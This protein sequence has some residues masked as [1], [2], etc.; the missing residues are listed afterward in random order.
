MGVRVRVVVPPGA[1]LVAA[2]DPFSQLGKP[3][4]ARLLMPTALELSDTAQVIRAGV[5]DACVSVKAKLVA[6][7]A[8]MLMP[9][10]DRKFAVMFST[11]LMVTEVEA[12]PALATVPDQPLKV[13]LAPAV[14]LTGTTVPV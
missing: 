5:A 1:T 8:E 2:R 11:A 4:I 10:A 13:N 3:D 14:A 9:V 6:L 7:Q 12:L